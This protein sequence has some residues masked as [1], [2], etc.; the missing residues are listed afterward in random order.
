MTNTPSPARRFTLEEARRLWS[1]SQLLGAGAQ[2]LTIPGGWMRAMGGIDPYLALNARCQGLRREAVDDALADGRLWVVP[3][4]RGCIWLVSAEDVSLALTV[5]DGEY[6]KRNVREMERLGVAQE[7]LDA[8]CAAV[9]E[10]LAAGPAT[11]EALRAA[12]P[13]GSWR[14]LGEEGK[15]LGHSTTLPSALRYLEGEGRIR[16]LQEGRRL[17]TQ[18]Y[19]WTLT[20]VNPLTLG[21]RPG[22]PRR[23]TLA[24]ARRYFQWAGPA[25]MSEFEAWSLCGKRQAEAAVKA[26][27]L[28]PVEVAGM[29]EIAW[30]PPERLDALDSLAAD[31]AF[32]FLSPQDNVLALRGSPSVLADPAH[33]A[34]PVMAMTGQ[35]TIPL[36]E[37]RW[38]NQRILVR[39]GQWVGLWSWHIEEARVIYA[40][41]SPMDKADLKAA[42]ASAQALTAFMIQEM[43]GSTQANGIDGARAQRAR[44]NFLLE[45]GAR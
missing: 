8:L 12:L 24:L 32:Y 22:D 37:A 35:R 2:A 29:D 7:E 17:D 34:R 28:I 42:D 25:T 23:Q 30:L 38:M 43:E 14:S 20:D 3:G 9:V 11:P 6:R 21:E 40:P 26:L 41:F 16:R 45:M 4:V 31:D 39:R 44:M 10:A 13:P 27:E 19:L 33:H 1:A 36:K 18:R 5:G 15:K